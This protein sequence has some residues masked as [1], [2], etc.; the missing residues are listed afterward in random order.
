MSL[1]YEVCDE[2]VVHPP[3]SSTHLTGR[4]LPVNHI[5]DGSQMGSQKEEVYAHHP[6]RHSRVV[7]ASS[8]L[9]NFSSDMLLCIVG[10][11]APSEFVALLMCAKWLQS[12]VDTPMAY[13]YML[14]LLDAK[15]GTLFHDLLSWPP[16][17]S[18][19]SQNAFVQRAAVRPPPAVLTPSE[20]TPGWST[21]AS[22]AVWKWAF[23][24]VWSLT[25]RKSLKPPQFNVI[26]RE[27]ELY[28]ENVERCITNMIRLCSRLRK[29]GPKSTWNGAIDVPSLSTES[30]S[31]N[32]TILSRGP[33]ACCGSIVRSLGE[34]CRNPQLYIPATDT[35]LS[36]PLQPAELQALIASRGEKAPFGNGHATILDPTV[37]STWRFPLG[38]EVL[39]TNRYWNMAFSQTTSAETEEMAGGNNAMLDTIKDILC[40]FLQGLATCFITTTMC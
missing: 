39:T 11:L 17:T 25:Q 35:S 31:S 10:F 28:Q 4:C 29:V 6:G 3:S 14:E 30:P 16:L 15:K 7:A 22:L 33:I 2:Y 8:P 40:P 13:R 26:Q 23:I 27:T 34:Q 24:A 37:R 1:S 32:S 20:E 19:P 36:F 21:E 9:L 18:A 5:D 12:L 38:T